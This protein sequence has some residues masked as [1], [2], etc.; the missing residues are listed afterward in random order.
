MRK[1]RWGKNVREKEQNGATLYEAPVDE[2]KEEDAEEGKEE[3][4]AAADDDDDEG[5]PL[6]RQMRDAFLP[7]QNVGGVVVLFAIVDDRV[8]CR[9]CCCY[10]CFHA[11]DWVL[12]RWRPRAPTLWW[13]RWAKVARR[14]WASAAASFWLEIPRRRPRKRNPRRE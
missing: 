1:G 2:V 14:R 3:D 12:R 10:C 4:D 9:Y 7:G 8:D 11:A 5:D 6:S 13:R